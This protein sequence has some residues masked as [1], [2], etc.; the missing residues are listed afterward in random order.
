MDE[1]HGAPS[2]QG[3]AAATGRTEPHFRRRALLGGFL[4]LPWIAGPDPATAQTA[5]AGF[6]NRPIRLIVPYPPGGSVDPVARLLSNKLSELWGQR[7]VI[8]NRPGAS[9]IIGTDMV[10]KAPPDGYTLLLTA[11]T[12]VTNSILFSDLPYDPY[13]DFTPIGTVYRAEFALIAHPSVP[14]RTL[15]ELIAYARANPGKLNYASAGPGNASHVAG[16]VFSRLTGV[17]MVHVPYRGGGPLITDLLRGEIQLYFAVPVSVLTPIRQGLLRAF[18]TSGERR[19]PILPDVP[20]FA[21]AG[22]PGYGIRSWIGVWAPAN[23]PEP[24]VS[25]L[26]A[27]LARV[28]ATEEVRERLESQGQSAYI[29]TPQEMLQAMREEG[30]VFARIVRE[31][32]IQVER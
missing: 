27:D 17:E 25:R 16:E 15:P 5:G 11:S 18:A 21:E 31:A 7:L 10:A 20:T 19:L 2:R 29:S 23:T 9:T 12:H 1:V 24:V 30:E 32:N 4:A 28:V 14:A 13:R 3:P 8:D 6:P 26:S 22:L